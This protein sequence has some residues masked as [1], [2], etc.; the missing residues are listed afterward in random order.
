LERTSGAEQYKARQLSASFGVFA[1]AHLPWQSSFTP[2]ME[3]GEQSL[4][5]HSFL[6]EP[7]FSSQYKYAFVCSARHTRATKVITEAKMIVF[8]LLVLVRSWNFGLRCD[9]APARLSSKRL[10]VAVPGMN[11]PH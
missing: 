1:F 10:H 4:H 5:A 3:L 2:Q 11:L 7:A 6:D 8:M 9:E